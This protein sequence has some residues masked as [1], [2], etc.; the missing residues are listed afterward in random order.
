MLY[1]IEGSA[2]GGQVIARL[3]RELPF[4]N[5]P[6]AF[7]NGYVSLSRQRWDEFF[8]FAETNCRDENRETTAIAA[9]LTFDA[10]KRRLD[11]YLDQ[12]GRH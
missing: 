12:L 2:N 5:L 8:E 11:A 7:F 1:T 6:M 4:K 9:A 10:I 3:L